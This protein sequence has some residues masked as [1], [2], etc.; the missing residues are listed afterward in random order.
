MEKEA[1]AGIVGV[2]VSGNPSGWILAA[3]AT[4]IAAD[5]NGK[6]FRY[7]RRSYLE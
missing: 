5:N 6:C 4:L 3:L 1:S 2:S 7:R